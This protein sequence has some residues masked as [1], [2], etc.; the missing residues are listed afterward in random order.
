M[1]K[2]LS[3]LCLFTHQM[4][5]SCSYTFARLVSFGG[6]ARRYTL[7]LMIYIACAPAT[8]IGGRFTLDDVKPGTR[9]DLIIILRQ[10]VE[11]GGPTTI[12]VPLDDNTEENGLSLDEDP[13]PGKTKLT[14]E[15]Q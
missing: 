7:A 10:P 12:I 15:N 2:R 3:V 6:P 9:V 14:L 13:R 4:R 5:L 11:P 1:C 8:A